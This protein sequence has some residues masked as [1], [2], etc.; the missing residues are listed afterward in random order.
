MLSLET[1]DRLDRFDWETAK[2]RFVIILMVA[3]AFS[4][5]NWFRSVKDKE[6]VLATIQKEAAALPKVQAEAGCE[7]WRAGV[8]TKLALGS[9][10]VDPKQIPKDC[11]HP[12]IDLPQEEHPVSK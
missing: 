8:A 10:M 11:V 1:R 4:G 7:H 12:H 2:R 9:D 5:G 3:G 6:A